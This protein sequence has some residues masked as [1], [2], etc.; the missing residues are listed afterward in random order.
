MSQVLSSSLALPALLPLWL[1]CPQQ[2]QEQYLH[3]ECLQSVLK[4]P[5]TLKPE[6]PELGIHSK[7]GPNRKQQL[8]SLLLSRQV[9]SQPKGD[10]STVLALLQVP[11][12]REQK[13]TTVSYAAF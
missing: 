2:W 1:Q 5:P 3:S 4:T 7:I 12:A 6:R 8:T 9:T 11:S 10:L 13:P